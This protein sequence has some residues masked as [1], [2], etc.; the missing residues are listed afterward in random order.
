MKIAYQ[1]KNIIN[2]QGFEWEYCDGCIFNM[3]EK[4]NEEEEIP[5]WWPCYLFHP[6]CKGY[7]IYQQSTELDEIF[8]V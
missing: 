1:E 5:L 8:K 3:E 2:S 7:D 4:I 6:T